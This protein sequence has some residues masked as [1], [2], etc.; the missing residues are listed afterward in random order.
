VVR[1]ETTVTVADVDW[2][3]YHPVFTA[4]RSSRLFDTVDTVAA[5]GAPGSTGAVSGLAERL[6]GLTEQ[7]QERLLVDLVRAE[8]AVVLGHTSAEGVPVKKAFRDAGFDSLTAVEL[9]K[10]LA[11]LTGLALPSTLVFDY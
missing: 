4:A 8:A 7:E 10:R 1:G 6:G 2:E 3:Q 5:L 11:H 9:R